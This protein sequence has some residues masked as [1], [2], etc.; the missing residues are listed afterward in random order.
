MK[1]MLA[2]LF[3]MVLALS[4]LTACGGSTT[5]TDTDKDEAEATT[6]AVVEE[7]AEEEA[8]DAL[9]T[10]DFTKDDPLNQ[11]DI[12][13]KEILVVSFGTSFNDSRV[14]TIGAIE[15]AIKDKY[16]ADGWSVRRA[17]TSTIILDH[18]KSYPGLLTD[19][20]K[21]ELGL[22]DEELEAK[23]NIDYI[24]T[25]L[26]RAEDN[27]VKELVVQPT[28]LMNGAEYA[29]LT[30]ALADY[31]NK[32]EIKIGKPLL[33]SDEDFDKVAD[34]LVDVT[35]DYQSDDTAIVFM[36]HGTPAENTDVDPSESNQTYSKM[37]EKL[38]EKGGANYYVGVVEGDIEGLS[39][40]Q[41]VPKVKEGGE[42]KKVV[43]RPMMVVAGDHA[44]NDMADEADDESWLSTFKAEGYEVEPII[45]G[46]GQVPAIQ[47][48]YVSHVQDAIDGK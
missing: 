20:Q 38:T 30:N 33:T 31:S 28:H 10:G 1:K 4:M 46:L 9:A 24:D 17:F 5:T 42:Y 41:I 13:E 34:A 7:E 47:E 15:K 14:A 44:N 22:T 37:Q 25:A 36:G 23:A 19:A 2:I 29:E 16:E 12:G 43:L 18:I 40:D 21:E 32:M 39:L 45:E 6:A 27:G 26:K 8:E 11:D 48:I 3:A 35:K